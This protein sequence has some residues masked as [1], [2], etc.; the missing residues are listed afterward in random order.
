MTLRPDW[1]TGYPADN[2]LAFPAQVVYEGAPPGGVDVPLRRPE[3]GGQALL[4][5][6]ALARA[7]AAAAT[8][9]A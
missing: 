9:S 8:T 1:E 6:S 5:D 2:R 7:S 3:G 4:E